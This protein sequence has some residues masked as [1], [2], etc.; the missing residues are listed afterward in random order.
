MGAMAE[1]EL[2]AAGAP[3]MAAVESAAAPVAAVVLVVS[4]PEPHELKASRQAPN[5]GKVERNIG[6]GKRN[7][8]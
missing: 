3:V 1:A 4:V 2:S 7:E 8:R 5:R 6:L